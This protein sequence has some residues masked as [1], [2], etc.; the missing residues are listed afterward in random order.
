MKP[1]IPLT[2]WIWIA[3]VIVASCFALAWSLS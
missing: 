3:V 2:V 1:P